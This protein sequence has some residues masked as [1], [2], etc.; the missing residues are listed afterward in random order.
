MHRALMITCMLL[1][2]AVAASATTYL[3]EADGSGDAPTIMAAVQLTVADDIILLGDGVYTGEGN[4]DI[5]LGDRFILIASAGG[6]PENCI[7]DAEGSEAD[8]HFGFLI[9]LTDEKSGRDILTRIEGLTIKGGYQYAGGGV[10]IGEGGVETAFDNCIFRDNEA[11][12]EGGAIKTTNPGPTTITNCSFIDNRSGE[13][14]GAITTGQFGDLSLDHVLFAGNFTF[15]QG[16]AINVGSHIVVTATNCSFI[17]NMAK[18]AAAASLRGTGSHTLDACLLYGNSG[19]TLMHFSYGDI[20]CTDSFGNACSDWGGALAPFAGINGNLNLDPA[21]C[22]F[23]DGNYYLQSDSPC[24]PENND[25]GVQMGALP[26]GCDV[27]QADAT[28][29]GALKILY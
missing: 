24:A 1:L 14:G 25:C 27:T 11:V 29:W 15:V 16:G 26:V 3:V 22:G 2:F 28:S 9:F 12:Y 8:P 5:V 6:N 17:G 13:T 4:R 7:I 20:S 21:L 19:A 18:V 23:P 10:Q